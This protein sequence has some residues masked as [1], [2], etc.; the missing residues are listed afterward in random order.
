M[1]W[2]GWG[3]KV[4]QIFTRQQADRIYVK[5]NGDETINGNK[6]LT[7]TTTMGRVTNLG[8][9]SNGDAFFLPKKDSG[10]STLFI[11]NSAFNDDKRFNIDLQNRSNIINVPTPTQAKDISNKEY[12]DGLIKSENGQADIGEGIQRIIFN[13][14]NRK[15]VGY[16][17]YRKR[18]ADSYWFIA[19]DNSAMGYQLFE[20]NNQ[21]YLWNSN[22]SGRPTQFTNEY[23][24]EFHYI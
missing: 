3:K 1:F 13:K 16:T 8:S 21:I 6:T 4:K 18:R 20:I 14:N 9:T 24:W 22:S 10:K 19:N 17:I 11:G 23:K 7:G 2:L 12:V 15:L 5:L